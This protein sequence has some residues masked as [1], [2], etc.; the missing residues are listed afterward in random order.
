MKN[1]IFITLLI[2]LASVA[3]GDLVTLHNGES[4]KGDVATFDGENFSIDGRNIPRSEVFSLTFDAAKKPVETTAASHAPVSGIELAAD[5]DYLIEKAG[6]MAK[7]YPDAGGIHIVDRG[8]FSLREDGSRTYRYHFAGKILKSSNLEWGQR[9]LGFEEGRTRV[10]ILFERTIL[11]DGT[12][13]W[14]DTTDY[15]I[16]DP[17]TEAGVFFSY[18]KVFS[19]TFPQVA[20]GTIVEYIFEIETYNPFDKNFYSPGF[21]FQDDIPVV[22]SRCTVILPKGKALNYKN[23]NWPDGNRS[24]SIFETDSTRIY[25]WLIEDIPPVFEEPQMP[26]WGDV[27]PRFDASLFSDWDYIYDWLGGL[28]ETRMAATPEIEAK[29]AEI[30]EGAVDMADSIDRVYEWVQ[31]EIHYISIKASVSSGQTGHAAELTFQ[32]KYGDCTDKSIL[33]ATMLRE[34]GVEAYPIIIMT[35][36]KDEITREIPDLS[37]NHAITLAIVDGEKVFLDATSTTHKY[38]YFREDDSGVTYVC[39][40]CREWGYTTTPP[41]ED[42]ANH[43]DIIATLDENGTMFADYTA[44]FTGSWEAGYRGFWENQQAERRGAI[45]QDWMSYIIPGSM[46]TEWDLPGVEELSVPFKEVLK[47]E[48]PSYPTT[49]GDLWILKI[50]GLESEYTFEEVSLVERQFD[51]EYTAPKQISH[52]VVFDLPEGCS[53]EFVP[54]NIELDIDYASYRASFTVE[55]GRIVFEDTYRLEKRVVPHGDYSAYKS[56]CQMVGQYAK[57]RIFIKRSI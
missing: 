32:Q 46:V 40:L 26:S 47:L 29:V 6:Q 49:A 28:Q 22:E 21:Y 1:I 27:V 19:A 14:W 34:I 38:P 11:P 15:T 37:G 52:R 48:T 35:N 12:E 56:F 10:R 16:T 44:S 24:P 31:R 30:V 13:A 41:P 2:M 17:S 8:T 5:K 36:D 54:E 55:D 42:N 7:D 3:M 18:G 25:E 45:L 23:Y 4:D 53:V 57:N 51:I 39:A 9:P 43:I 50:P 33:F 20:V